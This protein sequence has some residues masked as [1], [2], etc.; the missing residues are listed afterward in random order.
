MVKEIDINQ[1]RTDAEEIFKNGGFYCSE[2]V[3]HSVRKNILPEMPE[4]MIS[5]GSAF[6]VGVGG[7]RCMCGAVSGA[8]ICLGYVFGRVQPTTPADPKSLKSLE[9]CYELQDSFKKNHKVL[10]CK[11][12]LK[13]VEENSAEHVAQCAGFT[14]EMAALTA[15]LIARELQVKARGNATVGAVK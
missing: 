6:A 3:I 8:V 13:Q 14:G 5:A 15:E 1:V 7:A 9:L 4:A 2:S 12:H 11:V 10:C